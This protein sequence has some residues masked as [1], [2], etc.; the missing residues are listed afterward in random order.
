MIGTLVSF[1][2][3]TKIAIIRLD[4]I[5]RSVKIYEGQS[6]QVNFKKGLLG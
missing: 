3:K 6:M 5:P 2:E 4:K 1:D